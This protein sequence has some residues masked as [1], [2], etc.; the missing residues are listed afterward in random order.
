MSFSTH[1]DTY[2]GSPVKNSQ[3][4]RYD[5]AKRAWDERIGSAR[6]QAFHWRL[7]ALLSLAGMLGLGAALAHVSARHDVKTYVVEIDQLGQPGRIT[8]ANDGFEP[9]ASQTGYFVGQVIR[10][11]RARPLDPVV[12]RDNWKM[13]YGFLAGDAVHMMN[14]YAVSDP[15]LRT[16]DGRRLTRTVAITNILQ[17][18]PD[19]FQVRW[20]ETDYIGGTP[21]SPRQHTGLFQ[22]E[23][24]PPRTE[25]DVFKNPLGIYVI[26][27]SWSQE[28]TDAVA[29]E[30]VPDAQ[31]TIAESQS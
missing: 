27:F 7:T 30:S 28:F 29:T 16:I 11:V 13:A 31:E 20:V 24:K 26:S 10:L 6:A 5:R 18:S 8:L 25:A 21:Q 19:T 23:F 2:G 3:D 1:T 9:D 22:F 4:R 14:A 12:I 17:K 15:P